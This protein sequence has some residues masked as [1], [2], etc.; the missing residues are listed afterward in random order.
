[1]CIV[2]VYLY[3]VYHSYYVYPSSYILYNHTHRIVY[4][5]YLHLLYIYVDTYVDTYELYS[6]I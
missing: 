1:M 5:S 4:I 2:S 6:I 3:F